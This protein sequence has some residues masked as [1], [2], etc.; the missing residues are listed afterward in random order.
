MGEGDP[1]YTECAIVFG[2]CF[3]Q[4]RGIVR[5][6][7]RCKDS[8]SEKFHSAGTGSYYG[9]AHG[10]VFIDLQG[11]ITDRDFIEELGVDADIEAGRI[12][13]QFFQRFPAQE[14]DIGI[15]V[16][17][18]FDKVFVFRTYHDDMIMWPGDGDFPDDFLVEAQR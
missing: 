10:E 18:A 8:I 16:Q 3:I 13:G 2:Q 11:V 12:A 5:W 6:F 17:I 4:Q 14:M 9:L 15:A 1:F 7:F